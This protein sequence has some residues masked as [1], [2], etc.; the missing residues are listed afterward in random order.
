MPLNLSDYAT[1]LADINELS[2]GYHLQGEYLTKKRKESAVNAESILKQELDGA[3]ERMNQLIEDL[4]N[5]EDKIKLEEARNKKYQQGISIAKNIY[6]NKCPYL[7]GKGYEDKIQSVIWAN[8]PAKF[9][10]ATGEKHNKNPS[11]I[12]IIFN[13]PIDIY[14]NGENHNWIGVSLK[15]SFTSGD[16]GHYNGSTCK[17]VAGVM[18]LPPIPNEKL[19]AICRNKKHLGY[20]K[21]NLVNN[22]TGPFYEW[23]KSNIKGWINS[24]K[25]KEPAKAR[26]RLWKAQIKR[27]T[28]I[29][30]QSNIQ[31]TLLLSECRDICFSALSEIGGEL[32]FSDS[33]PQIKINV[34]ID[35]AKIIIANSLRIPENKIEEYPNYVK[36][37]A[38]KDSIVFDGG[39]L[40]DKYL[41]P[42]KPARIDLLYTKLAGGTIN[43]SCSAD[44]NL[45]RKG[46][47][48]RIKFAGTPPCAFKINGQNAEAIN[49]GILSTLEPALEDQLGGGISNEYVAIVQEAIDL[50]TEYS[51]QREYINRLKA[52]TVDEVYEAVNYYKLIL[53]I[54]IME[55][56]HIIPFL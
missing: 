38:L 22:N 29:Y 8:T 5:D 10:E 27:G 18:P 31:R 41:P 45:A 46:I 32:L 11:D 35:H 36:A 15:A 44:G 53:Y 23:C 24:I 42:S 56:M 7:P 54:I 47:N 21:Q 50:Y 25:K 1:P 30:D 49:E 37:S 55:L 13:E 39:L 6:Q 4:S 43:L 51:T 40:I 34:P 26:Q 2:T 28:D 14:G 20:Q 3:E 52:L 16:I 19:D 33:S 12:V 48:F 17:F 9:T